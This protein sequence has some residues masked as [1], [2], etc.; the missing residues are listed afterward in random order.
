MRL[1]VT[2][3]DLDDEAEHEA[4]AGEWAAVLPNLKSLIETG[5]PLRQEPWLMP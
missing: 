2:H 1:T 3:D 4:T 5:S